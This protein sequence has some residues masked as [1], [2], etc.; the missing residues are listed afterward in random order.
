[1]KHLVKLL[2]FFQIFFL[3]S[4]GFAQTILVLGDSLTEGYGVAKESAYP[5]LLEKKLKENGYPKI[6]IVNAGISGSTT[7]SGAGRLDWLLKKK[8]DVMILALGSNDGL[9]GFKLE[10]SKKNLIKVIEKAKAEK[11]KVILAGNHLPPNYGKKYSEDFHKMFQEVAKEQKVPLI[12]FLLD[13]V[14]GQSKLNLAD[15]IHP[16]EEGHKIIAETVYKVLK[17]QL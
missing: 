3:S 15:G 4:P 1:M 12:P 13:K 14:G 9:R 8:P 6:E 17:G 10:E 16:N 11:V 5:A 7:A 2:L